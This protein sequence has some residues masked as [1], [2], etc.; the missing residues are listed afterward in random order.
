[1]RLVV[2]GDPVAHSLSPRLHRAALA[3][4]HLAGSYEARRVDQAEMVTAASEVRS[5]RLDGAN[6][7]MPHKRLAAELSDQLSPVAARTRSVNTW[8]RAGASLAGH[9]TDGAGIDFALEWA[10]LP[11]VGQ[12]L[13]LGAGGAA[14]AALVALEHRP[15]AI[16]ARRVEQA[17]ALLEQLGV[18][19]PV[20]PWGRAVLNALVVN[21]TP[22][23]MA[24]EALPEAV[25]EAAGGLLD[26]VYGEKMT[27]ATVDAGRRG[28]PHTDGL[29]ML[30]GQARE[31]FRLWTG[32]TIPAEVMM[33]AVNLSSSPALPPKN[34]LNEPSG[35]EPCR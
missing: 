4:C 10:G 30:V 23:G 19:A 14:A 5:G 27:Q 20:V 13:V 34:H 25:I 16:S 31:S 22:I 8:V 26:M 24:G 12:V 29:A 11:Q 6:I 15:L 1:M 21:A 9:S 35:V 18:T 33:E 17:E 7:T 28:I 3:H 2:L 32:R